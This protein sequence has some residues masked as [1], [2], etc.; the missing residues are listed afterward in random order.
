MLENFMGADLF[1]AG[2][3]HYLNKYAFS[4]AET[5]QFLEI[6]QQ[7]SR[8]KVNIPEIMDTWTKQMGYPVINVIN[9]GTTYILTQKR[10][11]IDPEA[12][13]DETTSPYK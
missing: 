10:F 5:W 3:S 11:L 12:K 13:Y 6:L 2:V 4:N 8:S 7:S 9:E 1:Y